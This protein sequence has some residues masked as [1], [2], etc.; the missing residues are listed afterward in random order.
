MKSVSEIVERL[1]GL[2]D[3]PTDQMFGW[4]SSDLLEYL[5]FEKA[6]EFLKDGVLDGEWKTT[7]LTRES[8]LGEMRKYMEFA[9]DKATGHRGI[10]A[11]RSVE[12][13]QAW[14]WLLGDSDEIDWKDYQNYGMPILR[15]VAEFYGFEFPDCEAAQR[16]SDG[17]ACYAGCEEGCS[18]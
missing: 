1:R 12:H 16:M 15:Q 7:T 18:A 13:F 2:Q 10:S 4:Q 14:V 6:K 9:L 3:D 11:G 8:V 17:E 5:P